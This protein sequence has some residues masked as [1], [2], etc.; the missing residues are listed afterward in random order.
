ME[1]TELL[2]PD[3]IVRCKRKSIA[4]IIENS[5]NFI[6]RCPFSATQ[7]SVQDFILKKSNWIIR[8]RKLSKNHNFKQLK[9]E[10]NEKLNICDKTYTIE[11]YNNVRVKLS[12]DVIYVPYIDSKQK[13][14]NFLKGYAKILLQPKLEKLS[15]DL[16][17]NYKSMSISSA[18]T[19]WG[20]CGAN[21][22]IHFSYKLILCPEKVV[23]YIIIHELCHTKVKNHSSSFWKL[24]KEKCP[25]YQQSE[26]W[27]KDN[28]GI[29]NLI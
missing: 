2:I 19:C 1:N 9:I 22:K 8:K 11:L 10:T 13:F 26:K 18:K 5:G 24:V 20:S 6:V 14:I 4:L 12:N 29:I 16:N 25:D 17:L 23:D 21:N 7:K 3:K 15:S 28:R 27:L